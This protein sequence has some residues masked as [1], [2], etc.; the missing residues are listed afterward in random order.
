MKRLEDRPSNHN[1]KKTGREKR[2]RVVWG[3]FLGSLVYVFGGSRSHASFRVKREGGRALFCLALSVSARSV[4][5]SVARTPT[6]RVYA[7]VA[8]FSLSD[9]VSF[10]SSSLTF[11][12]V[13]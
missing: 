5:V 6:M 10:V 9:H 11:V 4:S 3:R 1:C 12:Q 13:L 7:S 2:T 8:G